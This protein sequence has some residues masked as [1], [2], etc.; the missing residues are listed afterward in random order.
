[1]NNEDEYETNELAERIEKLRRKWLS[2]IQQGGGSGGGCG[3]Q[4]NKTNKLN[5][6]EKINFMESIVQNKILI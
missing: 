1:M 5:K 2:R 6:F 3:C 4:F